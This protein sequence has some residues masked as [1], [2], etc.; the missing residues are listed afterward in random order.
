MTSSNAGVTHTTALT[1]SGKEWVLTV[2]VTGG[3]ANAD[4][5]VTM[6]ENSGA[7][8][9]KNAA[10]DNNGFT[11]QC[12]ARARVLTTAASQCCIS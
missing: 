11:L 3:Y 10:G 2:T 4:F 12:T 8:V 6:P 7:I 9:Q 5:A 1:G